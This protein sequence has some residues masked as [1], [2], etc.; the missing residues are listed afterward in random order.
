MVI[1]NS[2]GV[3][4]PVFFLLLL[5]SAVI[6]PAQQASDTQTLLT[7]V[8]QLMARREYNGAL[9]LFDRLDESVVQN[10]EVQLLRA[11]ILNSAGRFADARAIASGIISREPNNVDALLVLATTAAGEGKDREQRTTLEK[12]V[13]LDPGNPKALSDLGYI[14]LRAQSLRIAAGHF[15]RALAADENYREALV[16]RAIVYRYTRDP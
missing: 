9:E 14:A 2:Q 15:D 16:G 5:F 11:S 13:K 4:C 7:A 1:K 3:F 8:S 12:V 10:S 6:L